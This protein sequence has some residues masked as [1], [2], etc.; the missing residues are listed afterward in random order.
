MDHRP[1]SISRRA[2]SL[3]LGLAFVFQGILAQGHMHVEPDMEA[4][5]ANVAMALDHSDLG[6]ALSQSDRN[7]PIQAPVDDAATCPICQVLHASAVFTAAIPPELARPPLT[8]ESR[9][10]LAA[11]RIVGGFRY[12]P[13]QQ[14]APPGIA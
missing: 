3:L 2:A 5:L 6:P 14:R 1:S 11:D 4:A 7:G 12:S 10:P 13:S 8:V 9:A